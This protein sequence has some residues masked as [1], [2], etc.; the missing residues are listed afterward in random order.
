[1]VMTAFLINLSAWLPPPLRAL[2]TEARIALLVQFG[3]FGMVGLIGFVLDTATVYALRH[4]L[5]LYVAGLLA[6][7]TAA[8]GTWFFNRQWTFRHV[9]GSEPWYVQWRR[10]L[11]ANMTGFVVNRGL[12]S[13]LV[14]FWD[15]AAREPAIA[16][17][18][19][20]AA[21]I[22]LN[23]NLSRKMVFR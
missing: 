1:M 4:A 17:F 15:A 16:V 9:T 13:L 8:T 3:M 20:A 12:Y 7:F 22:M 10:F 14:T 6:Y 21:G 5:G 19:G 2:A 18:A 11:A 23:F